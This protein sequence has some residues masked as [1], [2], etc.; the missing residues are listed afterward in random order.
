MFGWEAAGLAALLVLPAASFARAPSTQGARGLFRASLLYLPL[1]MLGL[2]V[3]RVPNDHTTDLQQI[4]ERAVAAVPFRMLDAEGFGIGAAALN[5]YRL[6]SASAALTA[7]AGGRVLGIS[8]SALGELR[9]PSKAQCRSADQT[10][11]SSTTSSVRMLPE[12]SS[13]S[14]SISAAPPASVDGDASEA[15]ACLSE[16]DRLQPQISTDGAQ[17]VPGSEEHPQGAVRFAGGV[18]PLWSW[19]R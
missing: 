13:S 12:A 11:T 4:R 16:C 3:H 19:R 9:C 7:A 5:A 6:L 1:L 15:A 10:V 2:V 14:S 8:T 18:G 17:R